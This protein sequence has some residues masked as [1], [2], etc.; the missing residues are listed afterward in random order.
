MTDE[1]RLAKNIREVLDS[2][3]S[4]NI[5]TRRREQLRFIGI[6]VDEV[7]RGEDA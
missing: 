6:I 7:L 1:V 5:N 3:I 2:F 4:P